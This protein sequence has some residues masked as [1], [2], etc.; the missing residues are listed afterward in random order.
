MINTRVHLLISSV[1]LTGCAGPA[2]P[3]GAVWAWSPAQVYREPAAVSKPK[4]I[5]ARGPEIFVSPSNQVL[6]RP[7]P[8]RII[9]KDQGG[10]L[11]G[12]KFQVLYNGVDVTRSFFSQSQVRVNEAAGRVIVRNPVLRL[13]PEE[14]HRIEL[15]Y[16]SPSGAVTAIQYRPP[17]CDAF[18]EE[19]LLHLGEFTPP[20]ALVNDLQQIV[21]S[22]GFNPAFFAG[23]IA[24]ESSFDP[25]VVSFAKAIGLTQVTTLADR[26]LRSSTKDWPRYPGIEKISVLRLKAMIMTGRVNAKNEWRLDPEL[27]IRGGVAFAEILANR[28]S[29]TDNL[30]EIRRTFQNPEAARSK[31]ILASYHSGYARV[32]RALTRMRKNWIRS[33]DLREARKYVNS[34][35]SYCN[36]FTQGE[37][38]YL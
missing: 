1:V 12:H 23:L 17:A 13:S 30:A 9:V 19:M 26:E 27:S 33:R 22:S 18:K 31:L 5:R 35:F 15:R 25:K 7:S 6:H 36:Y 3:L 16:R 4:D 38:L 29:T 20:N 14:D 2:T 34:V 28:W 24:Q 10:S 21:S 37:V 11:E 32:R 8:V